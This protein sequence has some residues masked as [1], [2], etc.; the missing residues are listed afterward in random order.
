[1]EVGGEMNYKYKLNKWSL[2]RNQNVNFIY[3]LFDESPDRVEVIQD[4]QHSR[5]LV[6]M[7]KSTLD[8]L[9]HEIDKDSKI[10]KFTEKH[11]K[12]VEYLLDLKREKDD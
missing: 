10:E 4:K 1:M 12:I 8:K 6:L 9:L 3:G 2:A 7:D 5:Q 11:L